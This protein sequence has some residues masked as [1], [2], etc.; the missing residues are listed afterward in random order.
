MSVPELQLAILNRFVLRLNH[1]SSCLS[2]I[3]E[4]GQFFW[5]IDVPIAERCSKVPSW[6]LC[7][8]QLELASPLFLSTHPT[9]SQNATTTANPRNSFSLP[10]N[11][12]TRC[13]SAPA[14]HQSS[15]PHRLPARTSTLVSSTFPPSAASTRL[16]AH[17]AVLHTTTVFK[18]PPI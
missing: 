9:P 15:R 16:A 8:A 13:A 2:V 18:L 4:N 12:Q 3:C 5:D 14:L 1:V 17:L 7:P 11:N 6:C 10:L